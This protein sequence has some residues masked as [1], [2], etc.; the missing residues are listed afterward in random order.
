[1][2]DDQGIYAATITSVDPDSRSLSFDVVQW[3]SGQ[4]AIDD[5]HD[6]YPDDPDGPPNDFRVRNDN[7]TIRTAPVADD[8]RIRLVQLSV[9]QSADVS[10]GTLDELPDYLVEGFSS[11]TWWLTFDSGSIVEICEQ[12][13]P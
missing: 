6:E 12:Y 2:F 4:D 5:Y 1:M 11:T 9:D 8:A 10:N 13:V 7:P 3:L